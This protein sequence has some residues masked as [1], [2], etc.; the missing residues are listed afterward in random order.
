MRMH[1]EPHILLVTGGLSTLEERQEVV[2]LVDRLRGCRLDVQVLGSGGGPG[3]IEAN[4]LES[5][6]MLPWVIRGLNLSDDQ[7]PDLLHVLDPTLADAGLALAERWH[8]PYLLSVTDFPGP[9]DRLRIG[10]SHCFGLVVPAEELAEELRSSFGVPAQLLNVI[11]PGISLGSAPSERVRR[12]DQL[13]VVGAAGALNSVSGFATFLAAAR[14]VLDAGVD[15]EFVIAGQGEDEVDL[16]RRADR[17]RIVDRVTFA[18]RPAVGLRYWDVLD[19]FCLTSI[20]PTT[21]RSLAHALAHGVPSIASNVPGH[22]ELVLPGLTGIR[23]DP[24]DSQALAAAILALLSNTDTARR[25]GDAGRELVA[26]DLDP[27]REANELDRLYRA[28]LARAGPQ[29]LAGSPVA[30][31]SWASFRS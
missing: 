14:R 19:L 29:G 12:R 7:T 24:E 13:P 22:R 5:R 23:V 2:A 1:N 26:R 9:D 20:A 28:V 6:W 8:V 31:P 16:R 18:G 30:A 21:G 17:L 4:G 15:A 11:R 3:W 27:T 25:L 10:S